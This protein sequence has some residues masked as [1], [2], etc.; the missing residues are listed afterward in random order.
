VHSKTLETLDIILARLGPGLADDLGIFSAGLVPLFPLANTTIKPVIVTLLTKYY[1]PLGRDLIPGLAT[2]LASLFAG[3]DE[4]G[5]AI[6]LAVTALVDKL[7]A[8]VGD[9]TAFWGSVWRAILVSRGC[10]L[11]AVGYMLKKVPHAAGAGLT[12]EQLASV[13]PDQNT[14]V[15]A[16]LVAALDS[17]DD[18]LVS[19]QVLELMINLFPTASGAFD[20]AGYVAIGASAYRLIL[21]KENSVMR[22]VY[23]WLF[24]Q[25]VVAQ[26]ALAADPYAACAQDP[27]FRIAV[28][29]LRKVYDV[30]GPHPRDVEAAK[31]PLLVAQQ[32]ALKGGL[33]AGA[34][35]CTLEDA[36]HYS[37]IHAPC[38]TKF[39][40]NVALP[41]FMGAISE[42]FTNLLETMVGKENKE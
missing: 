27:S 3:M 11:A 24:P 20:D 36:V 30:H 8:A 13:A 41:P 26:E 19:R 9:E 4:E 1:A 37:A 10:R 7:R 34:V 6:S 29:A 5:S 42:A 2:V 18:V 16:A 22:R 14:Q 40:R 12:A 39:P 33:A 21:K 25:T 23:Q 32:L 28:L 17:S 38:A 15:V 35:W 31:V